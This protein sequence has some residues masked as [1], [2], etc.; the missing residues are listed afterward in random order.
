[1]AVNAAGIATSS[2][3]EISESAE[4]FYF[5]RG[6]E[7]LTSSISA[8]TGYKNAYGLEEFWALKSE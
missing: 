7:C 1:M 4:S 5:W 2:L 6:S 3:N 8:T